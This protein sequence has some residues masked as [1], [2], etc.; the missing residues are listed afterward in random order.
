MIDISQGKVITLES[1]TNK[2]EVIGLFKS[3]TGYHGYSEQKNLSG[4]VKVKYTGKFIKG[5]LDIVFVD[6]SN[7]KII[8]RFKDNHSKINITDQDNDIYSKLTILG[9][10]LAFS[11]SYDANDDIFY[12]CTLEVST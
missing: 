12:T 5:T 2:A 3:S 6:K 11:P 1:S 4:R 7:K 10:N 9:E 8:Q